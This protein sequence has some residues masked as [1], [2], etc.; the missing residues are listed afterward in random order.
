MGLFRLLEERDEFASAYCSILGQRL[1]LNRSAVSNQTE[2]CLLSKLTST[3]G[4]SFTIHFE[5]ML[6]DVAECKQIDTS[7]SVVLLTGGNW[8]VKNERLLPGHSILASTNNFSLWP[9]PGSLEAF[10]SQ[11]TANQAN[12]S[13]RLTWIPQLSEV[14]FACENGAQIRSSC[15]QFAL[16]ERIASCQSLQDLMQIPFAEASL[17][18]LLQSGLIGRSEAGVYSFLQPEADVDVFTPVASRL[19]GQHPIISDGSTA[20]SF[21]TTPAPRSTS[22]RTFTPQNNNNNNHANGSNST[23]SRSS[24]TNMNKA[25][26]L[27]LLQSQISRLLKQ[28]RSLSLAE[29]YN[30]LSMLPVLL[31]RFSPSLEEVNESVQSLVEKEF[32]EIV[33]G[34]TGEV[35]GESEI[36]AYLANWAPESLQVRYLA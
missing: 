9:H 32:V 19:F 7:S 35:V 27:T 1:I 2:V 20:Y 24:A 25:D 13:R 4:P 29:L 26:R 18:I 31:S 8:L 33:G 17:N 28:L 14:I 23:T 12:R 22:T 21:S 6:A 11:Y 30:R 5:R 16:L 3:C 10:Q 36:E 34:E 15:L